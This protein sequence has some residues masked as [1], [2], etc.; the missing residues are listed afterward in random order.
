[1][2]HHDIWNHDLP[3]PPNFLTLRRAGREVP[4]VAQVTKMGFV[5]VLD[6]LTGEPLFPVEERPVSQSRVPGEATWPTQPFPIKRPPFAMISISGGDITPVS[7][8]SNKYC[9][10]TFTPFSPSCL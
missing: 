2:V 6:R 1:M 8:S 7:P 3:A 9:L 10:T 5:F 4:A